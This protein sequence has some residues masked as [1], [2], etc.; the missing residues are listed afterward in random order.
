MGLCMSLCVPEV[1]PSYEEVYD[2][3]FNAIL[4]GYHNHRKDYSKGMENQ[5]PKPFVCE[6]VIDKDFKGG[7]RLLTKGV[8]NE[9]R[10]K[11]SALLAAT[12][13][14]VCEKVKIEVWQQFEPTVQEKA[15]AISVSQLKTAA[16]KAAE[17]ATGELTAKAF[18]KARDVLATM[19]ANGQ[20]LPQPKAK[21]PKK[22][23]AKADASE[24]EAVDADHP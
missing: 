9:E 13:E 21:K 22:E 19:I 3:V 15:E 7:K 14:G 18:E 11:N 16:I 1:A 6:E 8:D 17:E 24:T 4:I 20:D 5:Y 23:K 10:V 2:I 12:T